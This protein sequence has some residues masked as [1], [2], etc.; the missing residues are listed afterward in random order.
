MWVK[1]VNSSKSPTSEDT[2][3]LEMPL[4]CSLATMDAHISLDKSPVN[5]ESLL[6]G[7]LEE[8]DTGRTLEELWGTFE[9]LNW[10]SKACE[11]GSLEE[12]ATAEV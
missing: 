3:L 10:S 11:T 1:L 6:S 7:T 8:L 12:Q 5:P 4:P 2:K 9:E